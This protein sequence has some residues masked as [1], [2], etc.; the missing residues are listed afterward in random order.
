MKRIVQKEDAGCGIACVAMLAEVSYCA[1][2]RKLSPKFLRRL[3]EDGMR[4]K[5]LRDALS[6][7]DFVTPKRL[8]RFRSWKELKRDGRDAVLKLR[9]RR[10]GWWHWVVWDAARG[11]PP[12]DPAKA[13]DRYE[14]FHITS[15]LPV[16]R[17][18]KRSPR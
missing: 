16:G 1:V 2:R 12:L 11:Y 6:K 18:R 13:K 9:T 10:D 14:R 17:P 5:E 4:T 7:Y 3:N 15:F 8:V